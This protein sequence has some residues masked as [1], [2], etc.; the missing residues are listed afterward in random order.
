MYCEVKFEF[1]LAHYKARI[2]IFQRIYQLSY[3]IREVLLFTASD[4]LYK[5]EEVL[6][7]TSSTASDYTK[8][9]RFYLHTLFSLGLEILA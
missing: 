4:Y 5:I 7:I 8:S 6:F 1:N 3:E 9:K 2:W